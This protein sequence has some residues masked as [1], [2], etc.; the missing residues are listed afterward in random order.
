VGFV[1]RSEVTNTA[2]GVLQWTRS[3]EYLKTVLCDRVCVKDDG[4][5][6]EP[7]MVLLRCRRTGGRYCR[8]HHIVCVTG[9]CESI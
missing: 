6:E 5:G 2:F 8:S 9:V 7:A 1:G 4:V 3:L